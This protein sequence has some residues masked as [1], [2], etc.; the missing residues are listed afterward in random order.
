MADV[1]I[2]YK[3]DERDAVERIAHELRALGLDVWFD[4]SITAGDAFSDEIDREARAARAIL[5]C[6]SPSA[7]ESRWV[8]AEAMIGFEQD[9]LAA[10]YV[11][12][13]DGFRPPTPFNTV[14]AADVRDFLASYSAVHAG[15]RSVLR[16]VGKLCQRPD[17]E[18]W[19]ALDLDSSIGEQRLKSWL[20][21]YPQSPLAPVARQ[22]L[23]DAEEWRANAAERERSAREARERALAEKAERERDLWRARLTRRQGR[24]WSMLT[25]AGLGALLS[26]LDLLHPAAGWQ[27]TGLVG[28]DIVLG[29]VFG[30]P[31]LM[32]V[33]WFVAIAQRRGG[34]YP[35]GYFDWPFLLVLAIGA[36]GAIY[37]AFDT[38]NTANTA[39]GVGAVLTFFALPISFVLVLLSFTLQGKAIEREPD[40]PYR[41]VFER[42][43]WLLVVALAI[44][45]FVLFGIGG[46]PPPAA[47]K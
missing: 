40:P 16:R 30:G 45:G 27:T 15:W 43:G 9:K 46:A 34:T 38:R 41:T 5:I 47:G 12:G 7:R 4:A 33:R 21:S 32:L 24:I 10:A 44:A 6:W 39:L 35:R 1:F 20:S 37:Y 36:A 42:F 14:H 25:G 31:V 13:P 2:S 3:R 29:L 17:V 18:A 11:A 23:H 28:F 19:G 8:K 26:P 22:A